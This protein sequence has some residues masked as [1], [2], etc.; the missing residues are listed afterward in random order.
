MSQGIHYDNLVQGF[1]DLIDNMLS[2]YVLQGYAALADY[3]KTPLMLAVVLYIMLYGLAVTQGLLTVSVSQL[4]KR[5]I[6]LSVV[7]SLSLHWQ[8]FNSLFL[9]GLQQSAE[10]LALHLLGGLN[11][12]GHLFES[13]TLTD[14]IQDTLNNVLQQANQFFR[15]GGIMNPAPWLA[16][17][18][19]AG[20]GIAGILL[21][22]LQ[23]VIAKVALAI[24]FGLAPLFFGLLLFQSTRSLSERWFGYVVG[25]LLMFIFVNAALGGTLSL[26]SWALTD[27]KLVDENSLRWIHLMPILLVGCASF[28]LIRHAAAIGQ[29]IGGA[30]VF[31]SIGE[32]FS[33]LGSVVSTMHYGASA[34]KKLSRPF[35]SAKHYEESEK[36]SSPSVTILAIQQNIRQAEIID[37]QHH[38][39]VSK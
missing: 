32:A 10:Q 21:A 23:I 26:M 36:E 14:A 27:M 13:H 39:M 2:E 24:L 29:A 25:Y 15:I 19:M 22:L 30:V 18:I 33:E 31:S 8:I 5:V 17:L 35:S 34:I 12:S 4:T 3:L 7:C 6:K 1:L 20:F 9:Q 28:T 16:G 37:D 38:T 11:H